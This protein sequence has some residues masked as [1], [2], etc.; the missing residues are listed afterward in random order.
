MAVAA[1]A[2]HLPAVCSD[3]TCSS[4][5]SLIPLAASTLCWSWFLRYE[6][7]CT[8]DRFAFLRKKELY[9]VCILC[10]ESLVIRNLASLPLGTIG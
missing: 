7:V 3:A 4:V 5:F 8:T 2:I 1:A 9:G 6:E 10:H